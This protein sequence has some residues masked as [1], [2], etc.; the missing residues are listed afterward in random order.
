MQQVHEAD[1]EA[2]AD[3]EDDHETDD[4][5]NPASVL[6]REFSSELPVEGVACGESQT[7]GD[8]GSGAADGVE[9]RADRQLAS[10]HD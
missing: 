7:A 5:G 8:S 2:D 6:R 3:A 10:V 4:Y 9:P 1:A